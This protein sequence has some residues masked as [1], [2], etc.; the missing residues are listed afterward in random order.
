MLL[1][2][3]SLASPL[4]FSSLTEWLEHQEPWSELPIIFLTHPGQPTRVTG[5]RSRVLSL[6]AAVTV[7]ERPLRPATLVGALRVALQSRERQYQLRD[8]LESQRR[9][10]I[11]LQNAR[12]EAEAADRAK[13]Q[14]LAILSHE[15]RTPLNAILGWTY[16]MRDARNDE[17]LIGQGLEVLQRNTKTLIEL[18]SDLLDTSRIVAG[19]LTLDFQDVDLKQAVKAS[20]ETL[21]VQAAEKG[22]SASEYWKRFGMI[23]SRVSG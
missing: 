9:A 2:E 4:E 15:L 5:Q 13:D 17:S 14:F 16:I 12:L 23:S 22:S 20:L 3:E 1:T 21:R 7:L 19:T 6:R 10:G 18:I 8:L 11:E